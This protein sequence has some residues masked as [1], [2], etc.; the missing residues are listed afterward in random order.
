ME[1]ETPRIYA[2]RFTGRALRDITAAHTRFIELTGEEVAD[3]WE[4]GLYDAA[5]TLATTP[6]RPFAPENARFRQ[7]VRQILYRRRPG[8]VAYRVLFTIREQTEFDPPTVFVMHVRHG[9]AR[10]VTRA[11]AREIESEP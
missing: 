10:P 3:E 8:A 5:A 1:P 11:E 9:A 7:E 2:V 6:R 4:A